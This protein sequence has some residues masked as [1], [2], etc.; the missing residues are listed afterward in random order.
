MYKSWRLNEVAAEK[1]GATA[2]Q[3]QLY[4]QQDE[5]DGLKEN[6]GESEDARNKQIEK[7]K[8]LKKEVEE[9]NALLRR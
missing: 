8:H 3:D 2:L 6:V 7:I 9:S 5:L 1:Q 4:G